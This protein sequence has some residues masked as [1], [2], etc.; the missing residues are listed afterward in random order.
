MSRLP[1][2]LLLALAA[3]PVLAR[4]R[5]I[6]PATPTGPAVDCISTINLRTRVRSDDVIDFIVAGQ[7]YRN[8]L[9]QSCPTLGFEQRFAYRLQ[10]TRLC[11]LDIITILQDPGLSRGPSC[12]LGKFQPVDI[13]RKDR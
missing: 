6:P 12:G 7:T 3:T 13:P 8:T 1:L 10:T 9:P 11:S 4:T 2:A 5:E